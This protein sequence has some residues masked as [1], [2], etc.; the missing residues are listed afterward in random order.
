MG[1]LDE[2]KLISESN[3][4]NLIQEVCNRE[5]MFVNQ[6]VSTMSRIKRR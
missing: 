6:S 3:L 1:L 5:F 2:Q 4:K